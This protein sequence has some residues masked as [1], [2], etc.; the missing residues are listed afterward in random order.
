MTTVEIVVEVVTPIGVALFTVLIKE[1]VSKYKSLMCGF[2]PSISQVPTVPEFNV[3]QYLERIEKVSD[4][5]LRQRSD[6][7]TLVLWAGLDGLK[8]NPDGSTRWIKKAADKPPTKQCEGKRKLSKSEISELIYSEMKS[9]TELRHIEQRVKDLENKTSLYNSIQKHRNLIRYYKLLLAVCEDDSRDIPS[10]TLDDTCYKSYV[11][12]SCC[13]LQFLATR[14]SMQNANTMSLQ[15]E[16]AAQMANCTATI[17][18]NIMNQTQALDRD[19][20]TLR[21]QMAQQEQ[22]TCVINNLYL[23]APEHTL[24][25]D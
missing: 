1:L 9:L 11:S 22:N 8:M 23:K 10:T 25:R 2:R 13:N 17:N 5:L 24:W 3:A 7:Y 19:I 15:N 14:D 16:M 21:L 12:S 6:S 18:A 4:D 20:Q